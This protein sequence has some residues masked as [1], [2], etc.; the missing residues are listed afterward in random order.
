MKKRILAIL[1]ALSML[2]SCAALAE[3]YA[4]PSDLE[5]GTTVVE[6]PAAPEEGPAAEE[7]FVAVGYVQAKNGT[8]VY[9]DE[10]MTE[11]LGTLGKDAVVYAFSA[12]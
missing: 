2:A 3:E 1:L 12:S 7:P 5:E 8:A 9:A 10:D 4:T 6:E 11:K